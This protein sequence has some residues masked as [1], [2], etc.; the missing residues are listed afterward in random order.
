MEFPEHVTEESEAGVEQMDVGQFVAEEPQVPMRMK[1]E[2][3]WLKRKD[4]QAQKLNEQEETIRALRAKLRRY[5]DAEMRS[6]MK[7]TT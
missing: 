2:M 6:L 1:R 7:M 4:S 3:A 5:E